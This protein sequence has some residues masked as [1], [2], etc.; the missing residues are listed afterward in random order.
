MDKKKAGLKLVN[1]MAAKAQKYTQ[2]SQQ[3]GQPGILQLLK[4]GD[5]AR[6]I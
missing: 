4:Q 3:Q 6:R 1:K 2:E 5:N